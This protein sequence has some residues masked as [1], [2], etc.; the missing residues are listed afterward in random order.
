ME[1]VE[2]FRYLISVFLC[3]RAGIDVMEHTHLI[4][5]MTV[6]SRTPI[7]DDL[8]CENMFAL[9][10]VMRPCHDAHIGPEH[11]N[12]SERHLC[13]GL[14]MTL[15]CF[16][17]KRFVLS[18]VRVMIPSD[19]PIHIEQ[20]APQG[21]PR[22]ENSGEICSYDALAKFCLSLGQYRFPPRLL[23]W[24]RRDIEKLLRFRDTCKRVGC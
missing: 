5:I 3:V 21:V 23:A 8:S 20:Y 18:T 16:Q 17:S 4:I 9:T 14:P 11:G 15:S 12:S 13:L 22:F 10:P 19:D 2:E 1:T 7:L 6:S 24:K